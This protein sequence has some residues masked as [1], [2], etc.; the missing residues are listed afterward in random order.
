M[1]EA[2]VDTEVKKNKKKKTTKNEIIR[3]NH[4]LPA[5]CRNALHLMSFVIVK[6]EKIGL[7]LREIKRGKKS[8]ELGENM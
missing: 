6:C 8:R 1:K 4:F 5:V 2:V 3:L 7:R